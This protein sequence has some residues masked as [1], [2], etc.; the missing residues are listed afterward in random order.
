MVSWSHKYKQLLT[1]IQFVGDH[2]VSQDFPHGN[3]K[4]TNMPYHRSPPSLLRE[5]EAE[6][7]SEKPSTIYKRKI[8]EAPGEDSSK[9]CV[10]RNI[11]QV[12]NARQ[13]LKRNSEGV[14]ETMMVQVKMR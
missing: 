13:N 9:T 14:V 8:S 6:V 10:P 7:G 5:L 4:L 11:T 1:L 2:T 12:R 3:S